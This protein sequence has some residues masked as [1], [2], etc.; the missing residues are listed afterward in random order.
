MIPLE[1]CLPHSFDVVR[2]VLKAGEPEL[3]VDWLRRLLDCPIEPLLPMTL[4]EYLGGDQDPDVVAIG[5]D[6][7]SAW[8]ASTHRLTFDVGA[9][10]WNS[11]E[12]RDG[13]LR[14]LAHD[15]ATGWNRI[16][17]WL[18]DEPERIYD[19]GRGSLEPVSEGQ[20]D[21]E[22]FKDWPIMGLRIMAP[23]HFAPM[24]ADR[25]ASDELI[26]RYVEVAF[27]LHAVPFLE[28]W[29]WPVTTYRIGGPGLVAGVSEG[30]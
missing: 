8:I 12:M 20:L 5:H 16:D 15:V 13:E 29:D 3:V 10:P 19:N 4:G 6:E 9:S 7:T 26:Y 1:T 25:E 11:L 18:H 28:T 24:D 22:R 30:E 21:F 17:W 27:D 23:A 14:R 2:W